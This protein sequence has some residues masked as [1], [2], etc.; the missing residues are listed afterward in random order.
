MKPSIFYP[1][2]VKP[3]CVWEVAV[4]CVKNKF[5]K[6]FQKNY[7][8]LQKYIFFV[9][10]GIRTQDLQHG[11]P[12]L[13][14]KTM[15]VDEELR[16]FPCLYFK[17]LKKSAA[18]EKNCHLSNTFWLYQYGV[19]YEPLQCYSHLLSFFAFI[20]KVQLWETLISLCYSLKNQSHT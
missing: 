17:C 14:L 3:K 12:E 6:K 8:F 13:S 5:F 9:L 11:N 18:P 20:D 2:L 7:K 16:H 10:R 19:K 4:F 15:K 1:M